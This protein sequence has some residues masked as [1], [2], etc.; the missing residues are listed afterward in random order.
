MGVG[1]VGAQE[2]L[3]RGDVRLFAVC[4]HADPATAEGACAREELEAA[5][6]EAEVLD[7]GVHFGRFARRVSRIA[8]PEDHVRVYG[9]ACFGLEVW[10]GD[11]DG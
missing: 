7:E 8:F 10:N 4:E 6:A 11:K 9:R 1:V 3:N 2:R 5:E